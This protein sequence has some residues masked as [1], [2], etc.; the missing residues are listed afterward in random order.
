MARTRPER[1]PAPTSPASVLVATAIASAVLAVYLLRLDRV[2]GL[3]VDDAWYVLLA[4][5]LAEGHGFRLISSA[6]TEI[7]P[8]VPP[9][10]PA[11]LSVVFR[12]SPQ[13]PQNVLLLKSVSIAAMMG[14]GVVTYRYFVGYRQ[15]P[16]QLA[17]YIS[18]A[19]VV[20]PAFVFLAT[21][22]VMSECVF[23]F[24]QVLT[25]LLVER[26]AGA[27]DE[28]AGRRY[29]VIAAVLAVA[30]TLIRLPGVAL[31]VAAVLYLLKERLWRRAVLFAAV[32]MVCFAPWTVYERTHRPTTAQRLEHGGSIALAYGDSLWM[33]LAADPTSGRITILDL[34]ARVQ[35]NLITVFGRDVGGILVPA[36]FRGPDESGEEVAGLGGTMGVYAASMGGAR[37]TMI[38]SFVLSSIAF[39]GFIS[40]T[41]ERLTAAEVLV[42]ISIAMTVIVPFWS[43]RYVLP[44]APYVFF[45]FVK[46]LQAVTVWCERRMRTATLSPSR[47]VRVVMLCIIGLD[48]YD[49]AQYVLETRDTARLQATDW[50]AD[51]REIDGVLE[52]MRSNLVM[53][54]VVVTTNPG[55]VYLETGRKTLAMDDQANNWDAWKTRGVRYLVC[56]RPSELPPAS[57]RTYKLLHQSSR[58]KLWVIEI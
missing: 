27:R 12:L 40:A 51:S 39:I 47:L 23:T 8:I 43:Y 21:S 56:L 4:K 29:T 15:V 45:Y 54:G 20:T 16:R 58:R 24:G 18:V 19:T 44:L 22:T 28:T 30:T 38:I 26:S 1:S 14:V 41:R 11:I 32:A 33:R 35:E 9:G 5:A 2:A 57:V 49:H 7:L 53:D 55:L 3:M 10:F 50:I 37:A 34:P 6:A 13:F 31:A 17:I 48:V 36:F 52:W 42:P 46:G 25:I